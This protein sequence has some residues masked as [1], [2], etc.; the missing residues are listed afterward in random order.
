MD[1]DRFFLE[2]GSSALLIIDAQDRLMAAMPRRDITEAR[3]ARMARGAGVLS[4][5]VVL[6]EQYPKGLGRTAPAVLEAAGGAPVFE[7]TSFNC[8]DEDGVEQALK[9][10]SHVMLAGAEAH[11]CVLQTCLALLRSGRCVH[12]LG[13]CVASR[14]PS[15]KRAALA[16]M[17]Q[18]GA[19]VTTSEA[20]LFQIL[21]G[22]G[23]P[24]FKSVSALVK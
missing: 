3:V 11:I 20:A 21:G 8:L 7:K 1:L 6:T 4:V 19:V 17:R 15:D 13:D 12:V 14:S 24:E 9:G 18:A 2:R 23:A 22:A 10:R 16:T 5:P